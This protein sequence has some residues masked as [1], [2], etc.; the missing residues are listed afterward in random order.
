MATLTTEQLDGLRREL[1]DTTSPPLLSNDDLE[2]HFKQANGDHLETKFRAVEQLLM[3]AS[4]RVDH[5]TETEKSSDSQWFKQLERMRDKW[6]KQ[7]GKD[8]G[9]VVMGTLTLDGL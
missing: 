8:A 7:L 9:S 5:G 3:I 1:G 2:Y 6:A 4:R